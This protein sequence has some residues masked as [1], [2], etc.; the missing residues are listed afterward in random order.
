M[1]DRWKCRPEPKPGQGK[2]YWHIL[3][4]EHPQVQALASIGQQKLNCFPGLHFT[5]M[6]WL[7][8][9]TLVVGFIEEFTASEIEEMVG[10]AHGLFSEIP[11]ITIT[12]GKILYHRE[13]IA[14]GIRPGDALDPVFKAVR[15]ASRVK[16]PE[17]E[18]AE[19]A[20]WTP[21]VTLAYSNS[22]Q[23]APPIIDA[24]GH[25]LPSCDATVSR[26]NLIVQEGA[27][28]L[29][30]WRSIAEVPFAAGR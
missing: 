24:L 18:S 4:K 21:H 11:P 25:E 8:V 5:P 28:R 9:T 29:W 2:L 23:P 14:L 3:F 22:V 27:E 19:R 12:L 17:D 20:P 30:K 6:P 1:A 13:A 15:A 26:V 10:R 16:I 7:H